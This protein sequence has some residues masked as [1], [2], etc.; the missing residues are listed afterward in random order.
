MIAPV[1]YVHNGRPSPQIPMCVSML[2]SKGE[3][4]SL[5]ITS[6]VSLIRPTPLP[7][8]IAP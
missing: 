8:P 1:P 3:N 5:P 2:R 4:Y 7:A 6:R